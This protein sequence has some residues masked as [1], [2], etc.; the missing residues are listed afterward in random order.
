MEPLMTATTIAAAAGGYISIPKVLTILVFTIPWLYFAPWVQKDTIKVRTSQT[1]WCLAVLGAGG[2]GILL[3]LLLPFFFAGMAV[4]AVLTSAA[5]M[6]YIVHRNSRVVDKAKVLTGSH[7]RKVFGKKEKLE[8]DVVSRIKVY[9]THTRIVLAPDP[10]KATPE[11]INAYN[12]AQELLHDA[13]WRRASEVDVCPEGSQAK[14]RYVIDGM[15][16]ERPALPLGDSET[17]IQYI[18]PLAGLE[19]EERRRPQQGQISM[20]LPSGATDVAVTT[21]GT[22]GGQRLQLK[23]VR[24]AV[25]TDIGELGMDNETLAKVLRMNSAGNGIIIVSSKSHNGTTSTLYSLLRQ[26]DAFVKQLV[27]LESK[28]DADMENITQNAYGDSS[29]LASALAA[30]L[31]RDP[32]VVM[33]DNCEDPRAAALLL[34]A[35]ADKTILLGMK[36][37]SSFSAMAKWVQVCGNAPAAMKPLLG[38]L[39][40][41]LVRT[42][43]TNCREAYRP[44]PQLLA[45]A[46]IPGQN[47]DKFYRPPTKPLT[48]PKGNPIVCPSCQGIGY[49]G[50][51][52][53][54]ELI[55]VTDELRQIVASNA[56][57]SE[58]K[59]VCRKNKMLYLQEQALRKVIDGQTS[60]QEVVRVTQT[61]QAKKK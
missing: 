53:V 2:F 54:F 3:W 1:V 18:K 28:P 40:Q 12:L 34:E 4:Y 42:L 27:T 5:F 9:D 33:V 46:N 49:I 16:V 22:T 39:C 25:R 61:P 8:T 47:I 52:A 48:D 43:C 60:I 30:A 58:I 44:D 19:V 37:S 24:E 26:Q 35:A 31:R 13:A 23:I 17:I 56:S 20:D 6:A 7:L 55:E 14:V 50:R 32:D 10:A 57:I 59:A 38:V 29:N 41:V 15:V 51:T 45:K 11:E 21:A 36:A